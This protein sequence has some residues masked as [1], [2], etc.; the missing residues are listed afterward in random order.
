MHPDTGRYP[1]LE[2]LL[3]ASRKV[4]LDDA[5][6]VVVFSDLHIGD[7][8]RKDE[9]LHNAH[10]FETL[11]ER[12]YLTRSFGLVLNGDIEELMK[13][14]CASIT[15]A[16]AGLYELFLR[17]T[18]HGFFWKI[19]GNHDLGLIDET[20][21]QLSPW[22][23]ESLAFRYGS[24][25][26][27]LFHGHQASPFLKEPC[28]IIARFLT[29]LLRYIAKPAG[30]R[31][32]SVSYKSRRRYVIEKA[33]YEFSNRLGIISIIG[34]THWP[35]CESLSKVD[36]L[37]YRIEQLCRAYSAAGSE[38]RLQIEEEILHLRDE[39]DA[40]Y[41]KGFRKSLR[42]GRYGNITIPSI[43]NS[44]CAIGKRGITAIEIEDGKIRLV[45]WHN[46]K[47]AGPAP[48]DTDKSEELET[49]G[50][51]RVVLNEDRLDYV[52]S[53]IRLL[54]RSGGK[55]GNAEPEPVGSCPTFT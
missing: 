15:H 4:H 36:H 21:Y 12:Y 55:D 38:R 7:G 9:F 3:D 34:H 18:R 53:R 22:L 31:N 33:V 17:F 20:D 10:L 42:S 11:L 13:F 51:F 8:G 19:Y 24:D 16:W 1:E 5:S 32:Y 52:F 44:G 29:Y 41:R 43:F 30:I 26:I 50:Y 47:V 27:L 35:L 14:S 25:T 46:G 54:A 37:N 6:R 40:C 28:S 2:L 39:F 49:S 45:Y 23:V 48:H